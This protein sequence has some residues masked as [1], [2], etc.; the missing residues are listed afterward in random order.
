MSNRTMHL[1]PFHVMEILEEAER[2]GQQ[3]RDIIHLEIGQP[4]FPTP[5][6]VTEAAI[7][8]LQQKESG[9]INSKGLLPLRR[10]IAEHYSSRYGVSLNTDNILITSGTSP[11]MLLLFTA[12]INPGDE[13]IIPAPYYSCYPNFVKFAGGVPV[14]VAS[15]PEDGFQLDPDRIKAAVTSKTKGI[16]LNSPCNPTGAIISADRIAAVCRMGVPVISDEIYQGL[17]FGTTGNTALEFTD[18]AFVL[19]GF[20]KRYAMPGWRLG[21][22]IAPDRYIREL[23]IM[24]QNFFISGNPMVQYAGIAALTQTAEEMAMMHDQLIERRDFLYRE[25]QEAGFVFHNPPQGAF[26]LFADCRRFDN[27]SMSFCKRMLHEAGVAAAPGIDFGE[28]SEGF[29]RFSY[30]GPL[31]Q[32]KT[33]AARLKKWLKHY[34]MKPS[35]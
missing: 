35:V 11:A 17:E 6:A 22:L 24:L 12:L 28:S 18:N 25:L 20:S 19:N 3:G 26:Y 7:S 29:V 34:G 2:L 15:S 5:A 33:A 32:L 16:F 10:A 31:D 1:T 13:I 8:A 27:D 14:P 9:Y 21:Y 4:H 23:H 30:A